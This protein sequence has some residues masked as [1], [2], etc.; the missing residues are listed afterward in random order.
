[1][2]KGDPVTFL[3]QNEIAQ[4]A[5]VRLGPYFGERFRE[6]VRR[7]ADGSGTHL[8]RKIQS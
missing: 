6:R 4:G 5:V 8:T 3:E 7:A 1:M 2:L